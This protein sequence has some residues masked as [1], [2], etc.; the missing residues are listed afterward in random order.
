MLQGTKNALTEPN[1]ILLSASLA[2]IFFGNTDAVGK[3]VKLGNKADLSVTGVY[4]D[5]PYNSNFKD[6]DFIS[7]WKFYAGSEPWIREAA[8][9]WDNNSFQIFAQINPNTNFATVSAKIKDLV[10]KHAQNT[11]TDKTTIFLHPMSKWHLFEKFENGKNAGG[12]IQ[13]V[14]LF[15]CIGFFVLLLACINFMN[16][17]TARSEQRAKE[18]G[19]RKT[20]GSVKKQLVAQFLSE[21]LTVVLI[22]FLFT[23]VLM[24]INLPWFNAITDKQITIPW[25]NVS[26]WLMCFSFIFITGKSFKRNI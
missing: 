9:Q 23:I 16:L 25:A 18:V 10:H 24:Q 22:A 6:V 11:A 2:Q 1:S 20:I 7:T 19:I 8:A 26:F 12:S 17:S 14:W 15:G 21:S 13:Y 4:E 3:T 5:F